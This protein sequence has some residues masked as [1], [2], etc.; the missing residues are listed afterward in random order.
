M[1]SLRRY[2]LLSSVSYS[3]ILS[4]NS[5]PLVSGMKN[6]NPIISMLSNT[7][8]H[9]NTSLSTV[10]MAEAKIVASLPKVLAIPKA[11]PLIYVG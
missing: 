1:E 6:V 8:I 2:S 3:Q 7:F 9:I 4:F 5:T 10:T 11:R